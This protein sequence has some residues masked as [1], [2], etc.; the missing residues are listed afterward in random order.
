MPPFQSG[1][2]F[3]SLSKLHMAAPP[4]LRLHF[5]FSHFPGL[6]FQVHWGSAHL[7]SQSSAQRV[8]H[9][10]GAQTVLHPGQPPCS[11]C[12]VGHTIAHL[13]ASQ[14][15]LQVAAL[16]GG[17]AVSHCGGAQTGS[18]V[19]SQSAVPQ[20]HSHFGWQL[21]AAGACW[22]ARVVCCAVW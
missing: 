15:C 9:F 10:G 4:Q 13:G 16:I 17:Q 5:G 1:L 7:L 19:S 2:M 18:Q 14:A 6:H 8:W 11:Q 3:T 12:A 21:P 20:L 22:L